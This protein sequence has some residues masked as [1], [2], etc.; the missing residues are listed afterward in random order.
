MLEQ[1]DLSQTIDKQR[2]EQDLPPLRN[3][4][5]QVQHQ[6]RQ[7]GIPVLIVFEG[8]EASGKG[9]MISRL[10]EC[11]DPRW[12]QTYL[13]T[14]PVPEEELRPFLW[15]FWIK[16]PEKGH[17]ALFDQSWYR[18]VLADRFFKRIRNKDV[19]QVFREI[20]QFERQLSDSG[21]V[22]L[23]FFLHISE[24]EQHKRVKKIL[25][26]PTEAWQ[27]NKEDQKLTKNYVWLSRCVEEMLQSASP[28]FASWTIVESNCPRFATVKV[29]RTVLHALEAALQT[30]KTI[31]RRKSRYVP[32]DKHPKP[33]ILDRVDLTK[34]I[35]RTAY[36]QELPRLQVRARELEFELFHRRVPLVIVYEG[37]DAAGKGGNI[38]R[39]TEKLDP[40]GYKVT[41]IAAPSQSELN[42]HFLWRFWNPLQKAGHISIF[43]RSWYGRVLVERVEGFCTPGE[44]LRSYQEINEFEEQLWSFGTIITK[45]W[46]HINPDEQL[47]RFKERQSLSHKRWKITGEDWRNRDKWPQYEEAVIDMLQKTSTTYAPWVILEGNCKL[48]ARIQ[49]LRTIIERVEERLGHR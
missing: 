8:W 5:I 48:H 40:R 31:S 20:I 6:I 21:T 30:S 15:R 17:F 41:S 7:A 9:R 13:I 4:L 37:W 45:F 22:I 2:Y 29:F 18:T 14:E 19:P 11:L 46:I 36:S 10:V 3:R 33:T 1:V 27:V 28:H 39:V 23:K 35:E 24:T 34:T 42:H 25:K 26:D 44:W 32:P 49:A 16:I 12:M 47:R 38:R 43:D